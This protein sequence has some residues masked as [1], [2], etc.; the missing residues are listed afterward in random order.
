MSESTVDVAPPGAPVNTPPVSSRSRTGRGRAGRIGLRLLTLAVLIAIW[1]FVAWLEIVRPLFL[2]SP[3]AVWD[4]FVLANTNHPV[5]PGVDRI[6]KRRAELLP[7]GAP[8]RV[9]RAHRCRAPRRDR[10][11]GA[12]RARDGD[13]R[14]IS[15][16]SSRT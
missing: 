13:R 1:W 6:V 7:V 3:G 15:V 9:P 10:R 16:M 5:S 2:P 4:S 12:G 8:L 11:R 14:P